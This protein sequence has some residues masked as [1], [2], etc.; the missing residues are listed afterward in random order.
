MKLR[1]LK[2]KRFTEPCVTVEYSEE[3]KEVKEIIKVVRLFGSKI[4]A[5]LDGSSMN[6]N[7]E[8]IYY[9]ESVDD[10]SYIYTKEKVYNT[11]FKLFKIEE[12]VEKSSFVRISKSCIAN[13]AKL[14]HFSTEDLRQQC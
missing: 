2:D 3:T 11:K 4:P 9:F 7:F 13:I 10:N 1:I 6:I 5:E 8:D 14:N 12:M